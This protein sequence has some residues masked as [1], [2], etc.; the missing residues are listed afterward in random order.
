MN[1]GMINPAGAPATPVAAP[2]TTPV[3][4]EGT[5]LHSP[6]SF[7]PQSRP[8]QGAP[9]LRK[10]AEA[11]F[12]RDLTRVESPAWSFCAGDCIATPP[13]KGDNGL[14][15]AGSHDRNFYAL[16]EKT[17]EKRWSYPLGDGVVP[18]EVFAQIGGL[19]MKTSDGRI[20]ALDGATGQERWSVNIET[21]SS[22][23]VTPG[24]GDTIYYTTFDGH[25]Y[26]MDGK[27]GKTSK[28]FDSGFRG[29]G[30]LTCAPD[31]TLLGTSREFAFAL[32]GATGKPK[33]R[34]E[35]EDAKQW[36]P[37]YANVPLTTGPDGTVYAGC[38]DGTV[39]A[40]RG[41]T[42]EERWRFKTGS[43]VPSPPGVGA[44]GT[45]YTANGDRNVYALDPASGKEK[46]R[47]TAPQ[48][49]SA[50]PVE[51]PD[52][53]VLAGCRDG[54]LYALDRQT[55]E[56]RWFFKGADAFITPA[57]VSSDGRVYAGCWDKRV[58]ALEPP[59]S[60]AEEALGRLESKE[61]RPKAT[62]EEGAG[63]ITVDG[64]KVKRKQDAAPGA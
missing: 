42:G 19:C 2:R 40:L 59:V 43:V 12:G 15:Y 20:V 37:A 25:V 29:V 4:E 57:A 63:F 62:V 51:G 14:I 50:T 47:F 53:T 17:G 11:V 41:D 28:D 16:D 58:Y 38:Q 54:N 26:E 24:L 7:S 52:G 32:E 44:D 21:R 10:A 48:G 18:V 27:T 49:F 30:S 23:F 5:A 31:G 55:G 34:H 45:V 1:P 39:F 9:D 33:W 56:K 13:V 22:F 36:F 8:P 35:F 60:R 64:V 3:H 6:D 46:W 61:E